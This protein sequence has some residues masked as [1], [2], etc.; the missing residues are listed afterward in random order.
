[1]KD[2]KGKF[3]L[4]VVLGL[5]VVSALAAF[6]VPITIGQ[7][8]GA[9]KPGSP[10]YV[11]PMQSKVLPPQPPA[12]GGEIKQTAGESKP[13]WPPRFAPPKGAPNVLLIMLDDAGYGSESTFGGTIPTP[14]LDRIAKAG[15][16]Y[17]RF[18]SAALCSPTRAALIT[19]RNHHS[20]HFGMVADAA[21][22]YP[23]Y[24]SIIG[25]DTATV[26]EILRQNGYA[27][28]WFGKNHNVAGWMS[29]QAGPFDQWPIGLGFEYFYGFVGGDSSQWTPNLFRN[30][31]VIEPYVGNPSWNLITAMADEAIAYINQL[32]ALAPDKPFFVY[33]VPGATHAPHHP[34]KEWIEK[35]KGKFDHGWNEERERIF[36]NQKK[37]GVIPANAEL[38]PW[39]DSVPKWDTFSADEKKMLARQ[40]EVY[41]AYMAYT[42]HEIGRVIQA[43]EDMG[44]F[45]DT[46]I[47]YIGGDNGASSEGSTVGTPNEFATFNS[48]VIPLKEQL[49]YYD[50]WGSDET[51]PHYAVGWAWAFGTPFK[52]VKQVAS[53]FGGTRQGMAISWPRR[54]TDAGGIRHQFHHVIDIMPTILEAAGLRMP[55]I[56]NGIP[57][58]PV[59]G[60][61]MMY[62]FDKAN[63]SA[64]SVRKTQ[65]FEMLGMRGLYHEEWMASTTPPFVPWAAFEGLPQ[66]APKDILN[67]YTW[68][69]YKLDD[70]PTQADD[71][72]AKYPEKLAEMRKIFMD[73]AAKYNVLPLDNRTLPR[74]L[75]ARP[76]ATHGRTLFTYSHE[77]A[78]VPKGGAPSIIDRSYTITAEVEIP[79]SGAEG[80]LVTDGGR[81]G[82]YGFYILKGRPVFVYNFVNLERFRWEA[83]DALSPGKHAIVFDFKYDGIGFGH[84]GS[85]TLKVD[86]KVVDA[87]K[88]PKTLPF[89]F[90][91]DETFDVGVDTRSPIDDHDYQV[92]FR[93][94]GKLVK[95]T[96]ELHPMKG[97][98][99]QIVELKMKTRD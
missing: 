89:L 9:A 29:T 59:D 64:P 84:G 91:V 53:H 66:K 30:T 39:P 63:A 73:E 75:E 2:S 77:L 67:G 16:R 3:I 55:D 60:I 61:S 40:A 23:G 44:K 94:T 13:W 72:A 51:F 8:G 48:V 90:P 31:T 26:A 14:A 57:Q 22:G 58:K 28:S 65:Y 15:L 36:A 96:V 95:L 33:Y 19:G 35:F 88:I 78:N 93:F 68:E 54:I 92:P 17:T 21:T 37:L 1:M 41:A 20:A 62:T 25:R 83:K 80:M 97:T 87:K 43:V 98:V 69:L 32:N 79:Q 18:H 42:D 56:V 27:T 7:P 82:G 70:D 38:T 81:F 24:D 11:E 86:G 74:F 49:K 71:V 76:S 34:T 99:A 4:P 47:M 10:A 45:D 6:F 52:W 50:T 85:G 12:F 5:V 46:L